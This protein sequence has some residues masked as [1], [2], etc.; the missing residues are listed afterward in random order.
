MD[1]VVEQPP[2]PWSVPSCLTWRLASWVNLKSL[3]FS[4]IE[5]IQSISN[6]S[7]S[8]NVVDDNQLIRGTENIKDKSRSGQ[9]CKEEESKRM[10]NERRSEQ[11]INELGPKP[12]IS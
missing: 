11:G 12:S 8:E 4:K 6:F 3:C 1:V 7:R 9:R 10:Q 2:R 5:Y